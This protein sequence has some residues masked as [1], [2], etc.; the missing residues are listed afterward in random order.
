MV[1]YKC[2]DCSKTYDNYH[3]LYMHKTRNHN[4]QAENITKPRTTDYINQLKEELQKIKDA[5]PEIK[6]EPI[7]KESIQTP[8]TDASGINKKTGFYLLTFMA[9]SAIVLALWSKGI[10][11]FSL[12]GE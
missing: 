12:N 1:E 8:H 4:Y 6:R 3:A 11:R 2:E 10:I 7:V 9:L 5:Q